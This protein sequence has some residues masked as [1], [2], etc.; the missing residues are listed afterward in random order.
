M[1]DFGVHDADPSVHEPRS[2]CSR[3]ADLRVHD[4]PIRAFTMRR[5]PHMKKPHRPKRPRPKRRNPKNHASRQPARK[6]RGG[7]PG[8]PRRGVLEHERSPDRPRRG[9]ED[10]KGSTPRAAAGTR[11]TTA[12]PARRP[13][14]PAW[15][16]SVFRAVSALLCVW[17]IVALALGPSLAT[18]GCS[19]P[20]QG[21]PPI[22]E[23]TIRGLSDADTLCFYDQRGTLTTASHRQLGAFRSAYCAASLASSLP[24][25]CR[26]R[27][28]RNSR[29]LGRY[30][31]L[32][33]YHG[34]PFALGLAS[35]P[36]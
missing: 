21:P 4:P 9:P 24:S 32:P 1:P 3:C 27:A 33:P 11:P 15:P 30:P 12:T 35:S 10:P 29:R 2:W 36:H 28:V 25:F 34:R 6:Q 22:E 8:A 13:A 31:G 7:P 17:M 19:E 26:E 23:G 20:K 18:I 5:F 16:F 14:L